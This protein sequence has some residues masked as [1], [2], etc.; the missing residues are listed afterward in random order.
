MLVLPKIV[1]A[2]ELLGLDRQSIAFFGSKLPGLLFLCAA[3][4]VNTAKRL[5]LRLLQVSERMSKPAL[6]EPVCNLGD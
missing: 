2:S 5:V 4:C 6:G 1:V 3:T